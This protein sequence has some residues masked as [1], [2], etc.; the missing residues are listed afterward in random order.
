MGFL[1][2]LMIH[3][4]LSKCVWLRRDRRVTKVVRVG[5]MFLGKTPPVGEDKHWFHK[6]GLKGR[7]VVC[8]C[9][10]LG[11]QGSR[12]Q[13]WILLSLPLPLASYLLHKSQMATLPTILT[14]WTPIE[15]N[16]GVASITGLKPIANNPT[17]AMMAITI[18]GF[19]SLTSWTTFFSTFNS[20]T[21]GNQ[22][23][24]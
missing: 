16:A 12:E 9:S 2:A 22:C 8:H 19:N 5:P 14:W 4:L 3:A 17:A 6:R 15:A 13:Q 24:L 21:K 18:K 7:V 23:Q 1:L 10:R 20:N 11:N